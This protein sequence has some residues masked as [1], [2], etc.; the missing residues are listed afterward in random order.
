MESPHYWQN[1]ALSNQYKSFRDDNLRIT[2]MFI[3]GPL[4]T[5]ILLVLVF[6]EF[7]DRIDIHDC[8]S[9]TF[10]ITLSITGMFLFF[11]SPT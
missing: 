8:W 4:L 3:V 7:L 5:L 2:V 10:V 9:K 11:I 6:L 1:Y